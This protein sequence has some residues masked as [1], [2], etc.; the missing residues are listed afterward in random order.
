MEINAFQIAGILFVGVGAVCLYT[1]YINYKKKKN[2]FE[3]FNRALKPNKPQIMAVYD[4]DGKMTLQ[5]YNPN[6]VILDHAV[7]ENQVSLGEHA[8]I[9]QSTAFDTNTDMLFAADAVLEAN[10]NARI[11]RSRNA[12]NLQVNAARGDESMPQMASMSNTVFATGGGGGSFIPSGMIIP[13]DAVHQ[14]IEPI[15]VELPK[16]VVIPQEIA[17]HKP[18]DR[19]LGIVGE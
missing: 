18:G 1:G 17:V 5:S 6:N 19:F 13:S 11:R 9:T 14:G 12:L 15:V 2:A 16:P 4:P 7:A 10:F 8:R 3:M